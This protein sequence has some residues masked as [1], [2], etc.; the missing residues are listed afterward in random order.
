MK[1]WMIGLLGV[2]ILSAAT[3]AREWSDSTGKHKT[4]ATLVTVRQGKAY[5]E[6][7]DGKVVQVPF[8]KLHISDLR[9]I[10]SLEEHRDYFAAN[11]IPSYLLT[12]SDSD[13]LPLAAPTMA[14][15][16][17]DDS[18]FVGV[19]RSF[20]NLKGTPEVV[21][22][23][24]DGRLLAVGG[25]SQGVVVL[26]VDTGRGYAVDTDNQRVSALAFSP[27]RTKL[28]AGDNRGG[29]W[30]LSVEEDGE[31]SLQG[32]FPSIHGKYQAVSAIAIN[33]TGTSVLS[34]DNRGNARYWD[35]VS[36][37]PIFKFDDLGSDIRGIHVT[38]RGKQAVVSHRGGASLLDLESGTVIEETG[39]FT[40]TPD[41]SSFSP[42]G[43]K[44]AL[45]SSAWVF[46]YDVQSGKRLGGFQLKGRSFSAPLAI[47]PNDN[48]LVVARRQ[49]L[50]LVEIGTARKIHEF[51]HDGISSAKGL[52]ISSDGRHIAVANGVGSKSK[53][54]VI[55]LP[56]SLADR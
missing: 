24:S 55:R 21:A 45:G 50:D 40:T 42:D 18:D 27:D 19:I 15:Y 46:V 22:F 44:L 51:N 12:A 33:G 52:S 4:E 43:T 47:S 11:P 1:R 17:L 53:V 23:S 36:G 54:D 56:A 49:G 3:S 25:G 2:L 7:T 26:D 20:P 41:T 37:H 10:L 29:L 35:L 39:R 28:V 9:Y 13:E 8:D 31:V 30:V 34:G 38:P 6:R 5:L 16:R 48:F 32:N 14:E